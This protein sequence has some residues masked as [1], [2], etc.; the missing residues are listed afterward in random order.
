MDANCGMNGVKALVIHP[1]Q[2]MK[3]KMPVP[4]NSAKNVTITVLAIDL[5]EIDLF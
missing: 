2:P 5:S 1:V 3:S 4:S